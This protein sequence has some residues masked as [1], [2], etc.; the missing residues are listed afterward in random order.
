[1]I[2]RINAG[3]LAHR[4]VEFLDGEDQLARSG[5][6]S[7]GEAAEFAAQLR[8]IA[9]ELETPKPEAKSRTWTLP[10]EG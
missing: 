3:Y 8:V 7:D 5:L 9:A 6:L 2:I 1:M 4:E 10:G